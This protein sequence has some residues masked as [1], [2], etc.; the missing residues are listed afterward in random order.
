MRRS[1]LLAAK[2]CIALPAFA[3]VNVCMGGNL[4]RMSA[5]EKQAC[6]N[7]VHQVANAAADANLPDELHLVVVCGEDGWKDY[8]AFS[9]HDQLALSKAN[10][11]ADRATHTIFLRGASMT[12]SAVVADIVNRYATR[13]A[14]GL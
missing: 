12:S 13:T 5:V 11:D 3:Q 9:G 14:E 1:F 4:D 10:A 7:R 6:E 2:L 8:T